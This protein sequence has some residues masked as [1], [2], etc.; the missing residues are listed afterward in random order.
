M[1]KLNYDGNGSIL[2]GMGS[3]GSHGNDGHTEV[4]PQHVDHTKAQ[5]GQSCHHKPSLDRLLI[6]S[7]KSQKAL[8]FKGQIF[9]KISYSLCSL[10][11]PSSSV[12]Q[13]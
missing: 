5:K 7:P 8:L 12:T 2:V 9:Y 4:D 3:V 13:P 11:N 10:V 1:K 6:P